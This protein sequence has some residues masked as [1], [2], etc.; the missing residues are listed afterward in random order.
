MKVA[1]SLSVVLLAAAPALA[2]D[3]CPLDTDTL[4]VGNFSANVFGKGLTYDGDGF[5]GS[6]RYRNG[7]GD[8]ATVVFAQGIWLGGFA[9]NG[10]LAVAAQRYAGLGQRREGDFVSGPLRSTDGGRDTSAV[11]CDAFQISRAEI[12]AY[13][14]D[15]ADG[16]LDEPHDGIMAWPGAGNPRYDFGPGLDTL[17]PF[18]DADGDGAYDP[19]AGDYPAIAGDQAVWWVMNDL[20]THF[21]TGS[22]IPLGVEVQGLLEGFDG[23]TDAGLASA[24]KLTYRITNRSDRQLD[25]LYVALWQDVDLGCA[26][27][28]WVGSL[29]ELNALYFYNVDESDGFTGTVC[30]GQAT[31]GM[32]VPILVS[33]FLSAQTATSTVDTAHSGTVASNSTATGGP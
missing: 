19:A 8:V 13:L 32:S 6:L 9:P 15:V 22:T 14:L 31:F 17:A 33:R 2:Q 21:E 18:V 7:E 16:Q 24:M 11:F 30:G 28:D 20:G 29:P 1:T 12:E 3:T 25:S 23:E 4:G 27:D 10:E 26:E 5:D